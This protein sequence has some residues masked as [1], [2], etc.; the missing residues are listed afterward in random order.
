LI[1]KLIHELDKLKE[2]KKKYGYCIMG[3]VNKSNTRHWEDGAT[4]TGQRMG[5]NN[6]SEK[7]EAKFLDIEYQ[8]RR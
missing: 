8:F 2:N 7:W 5:E 6:L 1:S 3:V 4:T